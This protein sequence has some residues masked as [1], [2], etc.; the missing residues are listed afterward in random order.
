MTCSDSSV[1]VSV[2]V[3]HRLPS[4]CLHVRCFSVEKV[5]GSSVEK[6]RGSYVGKVR[7][8]YVR[9]VRG[10]Y[11]EEVRGSSLESLVVMKPQLV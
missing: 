2:D 5:M 8:S 1:V 4:C 3:T 9:S 11:V 10:S 6:V 7:G